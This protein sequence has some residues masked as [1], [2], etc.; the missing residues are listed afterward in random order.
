MITKLWVK[1]FRNLEETVVSFEPN[2]HVCITGDNNHGKTSFLETIHILTHLKG[3]TKPLDTSM[4]QWGAD[5]AVFGMQYEINE[6]THK[7]YLKLEPTQ[8]LLFVDERVVRTFRPYCSSFLVT[9]ISADALRFFQES[10]HTRR[11]FFDRFTMTLWPEKTRYYNQYSKLL[12]QKN[13]AIKQNRPP[14]E[15]RVYQEQL[16][17]IGVQIQAD[18]TEI[19]QLINQELEHI[20]RNFSFLAT[21]TITIAIQP[22]DLGSHRDDVQVFIDDHLISQSYSR[23]VN[24]LVALLIYWAQIHILR[25]RFG[26][27]PIG[28]LDDPFVEL[29]ESNKSDILT[30]FMA[31]MTCY[32]A[33][34]TAHDRS[35]FTSS[36]QCLSI[37]N[38]QVKN[39]MTC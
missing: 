16:E 3:V 38:G 29:D 19:A 18:R 5:H 20:K 11:H 30:F 15:W 28:L 34:V 36:D 39:Y 12:R 33:T 13:H 35:F 21:K 27:R 23:G 2:Q 25:D 31:N 14:H 37:Q 4:I 17:P 22:N 9:Y 7:A 26:I 8:K 24:R 6:Q 32:Y 1:Q 10:P